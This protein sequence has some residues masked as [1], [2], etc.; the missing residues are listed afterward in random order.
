M[1]TFE[2]QVYGFWAERFGVNYGDLFDSSSI[3]LQESELDQDGKIVVYD[4]N[5]MTIV[6]IG[7]EVSRKLGIEEGRHDDTFLSVQD[8]ANRLSDRDIRIKETSTLSDFFCD[9]DKFSKFE[10]GSVV[11]MLDR[12]TDLNDMKNLFNQCTAQEMDNADILLEEIDPVN[13]GVYEDGQLAA[14]CSYRIFGGNI[15]DAG[16]IIH[17]DHRNKGLGK[18]VTSAMCEYC[19]QNDIIPMCRIFSDNIFSMRIP[20]ML[21]FELMVQVHSITI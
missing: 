2:E 15:C 18:A 14:Y 21:G 19:F 7:T 17:P 5:E 9:S 6:R 1:K 13:F 8:I 4:I 20:K 10:T 11:R 12:E 3:V 16:V